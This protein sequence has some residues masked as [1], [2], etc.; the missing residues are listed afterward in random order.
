M[1]VWMTRSASSS[2]PTGRVSRLRSLVPD[3]GIPTTL[4]AVLDRQWLGGALDDINEDERVVGVEVVGSSKT[5][6]EKVRFRLEIE[7]SGGQRRTGSYC[8]K[9]HLDGSPGVDLLSEALFYR[10]LAPLFDLRTP[11]AYYTAIDADAQQAMIIMDDVVDL[12]GRFLSAHTPYSLETT[13]DSLAQLARLH[14]STWG[15]ARTADLQWLSS[16]VLQMGEFFPKEVLQPL[17]DDGRGPEVPAE[18][19]DADNVLEALRRT[20]DHPITCVIHGDTHSGNVYL[21]RHGRACWLD[22]QVTQHG[23]WSTDIGYHLA[24][25]LDVETR[26]AHEADLL[27]GYLQELESNGVAAPAWEEAWDHYT[28]SFSWGY[29][30]WVI[31]QV[32]SRAVVLIHI[33]R[34][35]AALTDHDTF[36]RLGAI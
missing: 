11:R 23:H 10:D 14:A 29:F 3:N 26:R 30:L 15:N 9:A 22:W 8:V 35:A 24:T 7:G 27:R 6:A 5:L 16:R 2:T 21:D 1:K 36:R 20:A 4:H 12:G 34:I 33:P 19:R 28:L 31:T 13:R 18:L 25:V 17:L 32:S